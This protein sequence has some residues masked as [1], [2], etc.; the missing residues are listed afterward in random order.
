LLF[1]ASGTVIDAIAPNPFGVSWFR[2]R[3]TLTS[4]SGR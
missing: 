4:K 1:Q 2:N 3:P